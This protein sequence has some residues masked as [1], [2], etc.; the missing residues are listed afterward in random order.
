MS[1]ATVAPQTQNA[2]GTSTWTIDASH[3]AVEFSV[4]HMMVSTTRGRFTDVQG[5]VTMADDDI[6]RSSVLVEIAAAS[7]DTRDAKRDE[8]LRSADFFDADQFP[9][10]TFSSKRVDPIG[11]QPDHF[12]VVG[13]L[14]IRGVSHE[15]VLDAT[16][17]GRGV[18]PWGNE[19]AGFT[20][21][22]EIDR[23]A[24]GLEWNAPL[25]A[26]GVLV[27]NTVKITL[28]IEAGRQQ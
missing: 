18:T 16:S 27:S 14:T 21:S 3:S 28:E 11:G 4:K 20:A 22:T 5:T 25:E 10:I 24:Y 23:R 19:V 2:A 8:H 17:N 13:D 26:G 6:T 12:R 1:T 7:I 9:T 15:V